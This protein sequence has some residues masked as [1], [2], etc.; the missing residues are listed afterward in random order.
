MHLRCRVC[1]IQQAS[2]WRCSVCSIPLTLAALLN[3][4]RRR[5]SVYHLA[6]FLGQGVRANKRF[7]PP[8]GAPAEQGG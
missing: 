7:Q 3:M 6:R 1:S 8:C 2:V 4:A 5:M